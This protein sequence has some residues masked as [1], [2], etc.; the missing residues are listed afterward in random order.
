[1][2]FSESPGSPQLSLKHTKQ[3]PEIFFRLAQELNIPKMAIFR[4]CLET[5]GKAENGGKVLGQCR[6]IYYIKL[7]QNFVVL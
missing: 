3:F 6:R 2:A 7:P 4:R 5:A 1:M